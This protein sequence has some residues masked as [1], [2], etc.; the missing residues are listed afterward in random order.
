[1]AWANDLA[2]KQKQYEEDQKILQEQI[3]LH[4]ARGVDLTRLRRYG[5]HA[6]VFAYLFRVSRKLCFLF[7]PCRVAFESATL[8]W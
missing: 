8:S 7:V 1:M 2:K 3:N 4:E 6:R 5:K